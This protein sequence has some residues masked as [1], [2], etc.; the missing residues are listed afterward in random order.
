TTLEVLVCE[1]IPSYQL[2]SISSQHDWITRWRR[3]ILPEDLTAVLKKQMETIS[4]SLA[5]IHTRLDQMQMQTSSRS[6][7]TT[8]QT[9]PAS[10]SDASVVDQEEPLKQK[11]SELKFFHQKHGFS[12]TT[13]HKVSSCEQ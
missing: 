4:T 2:F 10:S 1:L 11:P 12:E 5:S 3:N 13:R 9:I 8:S 6:H 7:P